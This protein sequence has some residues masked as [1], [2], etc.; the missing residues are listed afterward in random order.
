MKTFGIERERFISTC[1]G[2]IVPAI[3]KLLPLVHQIARKEDMYNER[4]SFELFAGQIEDRTPPCRT[5]EEIRKELL[6]NDAVLLRAARLLGL[7]FDYSEFL[8]KERVVVFAVNPFDE[9]HERIWTSITQERRL[10]ASIVAAIHVHISVNDEE[11][12]RVLNICRTSVVDHLIRIG[13]HSNFQRINAYR[14]M[15][16]TDGIPPMFVNIS[17]VMSYIASKGGEKNVWDLV[18]FKPSTRTIEFRMFGATPNV[19][20]IIGYAKACNDIISKI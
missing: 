4:F 14:A 3:G 11:A 2:K 5:L 16:G 10:A 20:E 17:E 7:E 9:R 19:D 13:D 8:D 1:D 12:V 18:R 6:A 15:A